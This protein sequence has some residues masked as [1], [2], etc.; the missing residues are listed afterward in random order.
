MNTVG[1][2]RERERNN[3]IKIK[4]PLQITLQ[5]KILDHWGTHNSV[6][7][8]KARVGTEIHF[9]IPIFKNLKYIYQ[10]CSKK[11]WSNIIY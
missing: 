2:E 6:K 1:R 3:K 4:S 10:G 8:R 9:K 11:K 5:T 7:T